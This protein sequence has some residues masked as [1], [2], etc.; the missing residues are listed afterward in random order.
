M[1]LQSSEVLLTVI[2]KLP[3]QTDIFYISFAKFPSLKVFPPMTKQY[4]VI[5][6]NFST[7]IYLENIVFVKI[8]KKPYFVKHQAPNK[9]TCSL[10]FVIFKVT[11]TFL[12][13]ICT[14]I[15]TASLR[16]Y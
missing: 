15:I 3:M 9:M 12:V 2:H 16:T 11:G 13:H 1:L 4:Q 6:S 14:T 8:Q 7:R 5:F 10:E